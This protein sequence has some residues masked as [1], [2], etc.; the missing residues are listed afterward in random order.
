LYHTPEKE[1][2]MNIAPD[3]SNGSLPRTQQAQ[4]H[5][6]DG[7]ADLLLQRALAAARA[8]L[9]RV[10]ERSQLAAMD[11]RGWRDLG[12]TPGDVMLEAA[13]PFWRI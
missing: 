8:W 2:A 6:V 12:L 13:K 3:L 7:T 10:R 4:R 5:S 9:R 1:N 11:A